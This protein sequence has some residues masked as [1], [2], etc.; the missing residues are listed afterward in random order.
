MTDL[1]DHPKEAASRH[2]VVRCAGADVSGAELASHHH[3]S[4]QPPQLHRGSRDRRRSS[5]SDGG[6][7]GESGG[8]GRGGGEALPVVVDHELLLREAPGLV[9]AQDLCH[10]GAADACAVA[11]V[12]FGSCLLHP[13]L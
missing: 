9:L 5:S 3:H 7:A 10:A 11:E 4:H 8:A 13:A 6:G 12:W 1:C 2:K